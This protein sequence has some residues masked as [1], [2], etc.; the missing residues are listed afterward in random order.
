MKT[1]TRFIFPMALIFSMLLS[2]C[3]GATTEVP[4]ATRVVTP[5]SEAT[6]GVAATEA[7]GATTAPESNAC[8]SVQLQYWN[9]FTGP[10]GPFMGQMVDAFNAENPDIQVTMTSQGD[11]YAQ[12]SNAAAADTLP[13]V[14]IVHADQIATQAFRNV[15]RPI[16][17]LVTQM[18]ISGD[19]YPAPVWAAG[20]VAGHR[21]SIP[22][23]IHPLT[24]FYNEDLLIAAGTTAAPIT[25]EEFDAAASAATSGDNKG[26]AITSGFPVMQ[27]FQMLLHQFGG[28]EFN[29]DGTEATW[30]SDAGVQALRWMKD[31]QSKYSEPNLEADAELSAF[32]SGTVGMVWNGIWQTTSVTGEGVEFAGKAAAVP[33]IG[34]KMAVWAGSHQL[35]LPAHG[36]VDPCR[37]QAAATF[38]K[39]LVDNSVTRAKAGQIPASIKVRNSEEFKAIEPPA[40]SAP[41]VESAFF[42][43]SV[44][45]IPDAFAPL[46]QAVGSVM[47]GTTTDIKAVLDEAAAWANEIL[48]QNVSTSLQP[49]EGFQNPV[50]RQDFPDPFIIK[51]DDTYWAYA[52]NG[53]GKNINLASSTNLVKW[54]LHP[55]AMP[56]LPK[57]AKSTSGL[58]WAPEVI[59][60]DDRYVMYYV[61]RDEASD[62]QCVGVATSDN[63]EGKFK[64]TNDQPFV[65]QVDQ[66]GTIDP[67][68]FHDEDGKLYLYYKNDG[69]CCG[70][71]TFIYVQEMAP[72][73]LSL[74]GD[75]VQL[76]RNDKQWEAHVIEAPTMFKHDSKYYLFYSANDYGGVP[77]AVGY[78][79]CESPLGPCQKAEENPIL[80]S[81]V[82][83]KKNFIIGP[84]H[85]TLLQL[86]DQTWI[87]YHAWQVL[88]GGNRGESR[89]MWLD[90]LNWV[91]G[92]PV[93]QGPTF[94]VQPV[95]QLP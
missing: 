42:P 84:G 33:Q 88:P 7:P 66:G 49:G 28:T 60:I 9:P 78:A 58:T 53:S 13:D 27:I 25:A 40:S 38:I 37:D 41:S 35:T 4:P 70:L 91:D 3:G 57:W 87:F 54:Q 1:L 63:P 47:N 19:D 6:E 48:A 23:D 2:A 69:N 92:K 45:G 85:Q 51:V 17:D 71:A 31:A 15:L 75:P 94:D 24:M 90:R 65:C 76:I 16:D 12:L 86:G 43:P 79:T 18:D 89:L 5:A 29:K 52:T 21:Y 80:K 68:P 22:L 39:Y 55:D 77:Y 11:Y 44:P 62:K 82:E 64:D 32:K 46:E 73:G 61:T 14:A 50:I 34:P 36:T 8:G 81:N 95:P 26:F 67:S 72:D 83:D 30:N 56:G 20:E 59:Q 10:D 93:V 74:L